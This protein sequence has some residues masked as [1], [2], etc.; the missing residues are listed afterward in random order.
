MNYQTRRDGENDVYSQTCDTI[1]IIFSIV[2]DCIL[3][4]LGQNRSK[5]K[6]RKSYRKKYN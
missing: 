3:T 4:V 2:F 5:K 6:E 1:F